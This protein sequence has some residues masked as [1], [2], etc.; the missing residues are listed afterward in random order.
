MK[1]EIT[2]NKT[3]KLGAP[4][5]VVMGAITCEY[6]IVKGRIAGAREFSTSFSKLIYFVVT[7]YGGFEVLP[8]DIYESVEEIAADL[9]NRVTE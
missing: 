8:S 3:F 9:K 4:V 6:E 7:K 2:L 5:Y 1:N